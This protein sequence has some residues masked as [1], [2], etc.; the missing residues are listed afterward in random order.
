M[1]QLGHRQVEWMTSFIA[2]IAWSGFQA[3][4]L[5][6]LSPCHHPS[7][8]F[9]QGD[10]DIIHLSQLLQLPVSENRF[11]CLDY[12]CLQVPDHS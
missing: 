8:R 12:K 5:L 11:Y 3:R 1:A 2:L 9:L 10:P 4:T 6:A 7:A